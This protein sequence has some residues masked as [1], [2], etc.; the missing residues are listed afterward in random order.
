MRV[1]RSSSGQKNK[2]TTETNETVASSCAKLLQRP[3]C[4][5][6]WSRRPHL[7]LMSFPFPFLMN[8]LE[9]QRRKGGDNILPRW[10]EKCIKM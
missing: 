2:H 4:S 9:E 5:L 8:F 10:G 7:L 1:E 6:A 3:R